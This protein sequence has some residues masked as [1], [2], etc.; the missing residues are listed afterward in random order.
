MHC[1]SRAFT[2]V[3]AFVPKYTSHS[4]SSQNKFFGLSPKDFIPFLICLSWAFTFNIILFF[5]LSHFMQPYN[6]FLSFFR[7][8]MMY[9]ECNEITYHQ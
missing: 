8:T 3:Y 1:H 9:M 4:E 2:E 6:K 5:F 7:T